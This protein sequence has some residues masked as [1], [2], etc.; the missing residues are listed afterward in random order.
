V[1][2]H[3]NMRGFFIREKNHGNMALFGGK[4]LAAILERANSAADL[5]YGRKKLEMN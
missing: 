1:K 2:K 5:K 3:G 4:N